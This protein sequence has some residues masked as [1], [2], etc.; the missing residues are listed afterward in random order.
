ML[1]KAFRFKRVLYKAMIS[2]EQYHF[3]GLLLQAEAFVEF[4]L[5]EM[6]FTGSNVGFKLCH[7]IEWFGSGGV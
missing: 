4:I 7:T 6:H 3:L 2:I 5:T 1:S